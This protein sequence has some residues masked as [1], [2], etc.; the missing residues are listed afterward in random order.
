MLDRGT[1]RI[2]NEIKANSAINPHHARKLEAIAGK[3]AT[4]IRTLNELTWAHPRRVQA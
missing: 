2:A 3:S 4:R 1:H